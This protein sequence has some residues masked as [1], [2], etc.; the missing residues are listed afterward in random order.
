MDHTNMTKKTALLLPVLLLGLASCTRPPT[1]ATAPQEKA[2]QTPQAQPAPTEAT[3]PKSDARFVFDV[4]IGNALAPDGKLAAAITDY[5]MADTIHV[6]VTLQG[7]G[8]GKLRAELQDSQNAPLD[9]QTAEV[10]D[11][12]GDEYRLSFPA[13]NA[14]KPGAYRILVLLDDKPVWEKPLT[15]K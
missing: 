4:Q 3:A 14:R 7:R 11:A 10:S 9:A 12:G 13:N 6:A 2:R 8:S 5:T 1:D 15:L